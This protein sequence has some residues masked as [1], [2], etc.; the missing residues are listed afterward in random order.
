MEE[1]ERLVA[2]PKS[3]SS[4]RKHKI[5]EREYRR[6]P[7]KT[8]NHDSC[9]SCKEGGDLLCCDRCPVA[10][11]LQ[12][13]D[14][15]LEEDDVPTGEWL[16]H[17][18]LVT[19]HIED[20]DTA[21][22][23]SSKSRHSE[24]QALPVKRTTKCS[25]KDEELITF[26][27]DLK[28][29]NN[30]P[31][32]PLMLLAKAVSVTNPR[33]F[34]LPKDICSHLQLPGSSKR[35]LCS[36]YRSGS[37]KLAH[38]LDNG[39]VPLPAKHCFVCNKSCR[40]A[41]LLQCDYCPLLFHMECLDPPLNALP[42]GRWMCPNHVE[43]ALQERKLLKSVRLTE[44]MKLYDMYT[45]DI[46][47]QTVKVQFLNKIHRKYPPFR[48]KVKH[49]RRRTIK[50]PEAV[51]QMYASPSPLTVQSSSTS[52]SYPTPGGM[53][54][55]QEQEQWLAGLISLQ[56]DVARH[57]CSTQIKQEKD[58]DFVSASTTSSMNSVF[59]NSKPTA[60]VT[61][62]V[63]QET[64]SS[65][66]SAVTTAT[67]LS[68]NTQPSKSC[69]VAQDRTCSDGD[70]LTL[71]SRLA[72]SDSVVVNGP[73]PSELKK[74]SGSVSLL[75]TVSASCMPTVNGEVEVSSNT[76]KVHHFPSKGALAVSSGAS[77][78]VTK[79]SR[80][81][82]VVANAQT[83]HLA[84]NSRPNNTVLSK[85]QVLP[86]GAYSGKLSTA[87][88]VTQ[89]SS[90]V[91][92]Q[93]LSSGQAYKTSRPAGCVTVISGAPPGGSIGSGFKG[94][95]VI[96]AAPQVPTRTSAGTFSGSN[97]G[98]PV[99]TKNISASQLSSSPAI[100]SLNNTLQTCMEGN[101]DV[102][103]SKLDE[104]LIQILALQRLQQLV[105]SMSQKPNNTLP[106]KKTNSVGSTAGSTVL[107]NLGA[108]EVRARALFCPL[109]GRGQPVQM[110]YRVLHIGT[111]ADMDVC[112]TNYGHCNFVSP[113]HACIFY[114]EMSRMYELLNYSEHGTTVDN[115]LYSCDFSEK[116]SN[117]PQATGIV[118]NVRKLIKKNKGA[119]S[120]VTSVSRT[121]VKVET[122]EKP[123]M[124]A[125]ANQTRKPCGC[126]SSG[127]SLI[128]GSGAGWEGSAQLHHGSYVKLGCLQFFFSIVNQATVLDRRP[129]GGS[130]SSLLKS[131][132]QS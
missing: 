126:K 56:V 113:K 84:M 66:G 118:A 57:L 44:K 71:D 35:R 61:P 12:C 30:E 26:D 53:P 43:H 72:S 109:S 7:G 115:V 132:F 46:S 85:T 92:P 86:P 11:H 89:M 67:S 93:T 108:P 127:S 87:T 104:R 49:S 110:P 37:K 121:T 52:S 82:S 78:G 73:T 20:D 117:T 29:D 96:N 51:R 111:G 36:S 47:Q 94:G 101:S 59:T 18:C 19:P 124:Y 123:S 63:K 68:H 10:F 129:V 76:L 3:T 120:T 65:S 105:P 75:N 22:T 97:N 128:G 119:P 45:G 74:P 16:C 100:I 9:D 13:H 114:D 54:T 112:L 8:A 34:E 77:S 95:R 80:S 32:H 69:F 102:D 64:V 25:I 103:L 116:R 99:Q 6:R 15:P 88:N 42:A 122:D 40:V 33:Q 90:N 83:S 1:I 5:R 60:S 81:T 39:I 79:L 55:P 98:G 125:H 4:L 106:N 21:S 28:N 58:L 70:A 14:P 2:P 91:G 31:M 41:P 24:P 131:E 27:F 62:V 130:T 38:E 23:C 17:K 48:I 107:N 50:V